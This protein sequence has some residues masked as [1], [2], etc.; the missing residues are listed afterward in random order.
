MSAEENKAMVRNWLE[1]INSSD[2]ETKLRPFFSSDASWDAF[3]TE[4]QPFREAF[5]DFHVELDGMICEGDFVVFWTTVTGTFSK[6]FDEGGLAG[7]EPQGQKLEWR[8]ATG[9]DVSTLNDDI[10]DAWFFCD[11]L[12]RLRQLGVIQ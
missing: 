10:P 6:P 4:H 7:I 5:P 1:G 9:L 12:G 2:W 8:E 11:E 3:R